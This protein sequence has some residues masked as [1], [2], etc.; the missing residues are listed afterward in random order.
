[1]QSKPLILGSYGSERSS[2]ISI[3]AQQGVLYSPYLRI[4]KANQLKAHV[5]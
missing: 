1:M 4:I 5:D 3:S 2:C